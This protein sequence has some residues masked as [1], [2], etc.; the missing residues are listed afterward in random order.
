MDRHSERRRLTLRGS[1]FLWIASAIVGWMVVI[2]AAYY[3]IRTGEPVIANLPDIPALIGLQETGTAAD[4]EG[5]RISDEDIKALQ[6]IV[7]AAGAPAA[8]APETPAAG[9]PPK[10]PPE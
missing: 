4:G 1:V 10:T 5:L 3:T 9:A 8:G 2:V 7:P 6:E